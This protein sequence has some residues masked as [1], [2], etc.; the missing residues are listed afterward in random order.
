MGW[1]NFNPSH[2]QVTIG[3]SDGSF[4]GFA[5]SEKVGWIHFKNASPAYNVVTTFTDGSGG[6]ST[7]VI[8]T[9]PE[10]AMIIFMILTE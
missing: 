2:S 10:W 6:G 9:M 1:I 5:W 8:P 4:D 7:E 3:L